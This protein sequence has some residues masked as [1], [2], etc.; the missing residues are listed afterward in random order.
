MIVSFTR[1]YISLFS[2]MVVGSIYGT[3]TRWASDNA[4]HVVL[5]CVAK[6]KAMSDRNRSATESVGGRGSRGLYPG[7]W[8]FDFTKPVRAPW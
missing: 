4:E 1:S 3:S 8:K 5:L 6:G 2:G 7:R